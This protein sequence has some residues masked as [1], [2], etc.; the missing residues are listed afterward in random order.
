MTRSTAATRASSAHLG[1]VRA[2]LAAFVLLV[3][4][5]PLTLVNPQSASAY[6]P[7]TFPPAAESDPSVTVTMNHSP[8][9]PDPIQGQQF[10]YTVSFVFG[11]V[12]EAGVDR[13]ATISI[14][15]DPNAPFDSLPTVG[16]FTWAGGG[17]VDMTRGA[18]SATACTFTLNTLKNDTLNFQGSATVNAN[19]P[20][21]AA[22]LASADARITSTPTISLDNVSSVAHNQCSGTYRFVQRVGDAGAWLADMKFADVNGLGKVFLTPG[23]RTIRAYNDPSAS[24]DT[25]RFTAPGDVDITSE[26]MANATYVANDPSTPIYIGLD[27][28]SQARFSN[29]DWIDSLNWPYDPSTWTG[30]TWL[31]AGTEIVVERQVSYAGCFGGGYTGDP[32]RDRPF[33]IST[34]IARATT[35]AWGSDYDIFSMPGDTPPV[36]AVCENRLLVSHNQLNSGSTTA[37]WWQPGSSAPAHTKVLNDS[38]ST[39]KRVDAI[40]ATADH[41]TKLFGLRYNTAVNKP[42]SHRLITYDSASGVTTE[43]ATTGLADTYYTGMAFDH[44]GNLW[45]AS[46]GGTTRYLTKAQVDALVAGTSTTAAWTTGPTI[47]TTGGGRASGTADLAFDGL[48]NLYTHYGTGTVAKY[49]NFTGSLGSASVVPTPPTASGV[50]EGL[51]GLAFIGDTLY[52]SGADRNLYTVNWKG[53]LG[54]TDVTS[55]TNGFPLADSGSPSDFASCSFPKPDDVPPPS[56][57]AYKV[58]KTIINPD[59]SIQPVNGAE[60]SIP[61]QPRVINP[62]GSVTIDYLVTVTAVGTEAGQFPAITDTARVPAGFTLEGLALNGVS[63]PNPPSFTIPSA[64]LDPTGATDPISRTYRVTLTARAPDL[65]AVNWTEAGRCDTSGVGNPAHGG[66]FNRVTMA[67][68]QDGPNN[69][70][71]CAP[72]EAPAQLTLIKE[73]VNEAGQTVGTIPADSQ[74]F[75][76]SAFG[77]STISGSSPTSGATAASGRV[78]PGTY[79]LHEQGNHSTAGQYRQYAEW[80]CVTSA[81][82]PIA[83][84]GGQ[85]TVKTGDNITCR[86]KNTKIPKVH[87]VK[88]A[89]TPTEANPHIGQ[90][91]IPDAEGRFIASYTVTVTNTSGFATTTGEIT[92]RFRVPDG[93]VWDGDRTATVTRLGTAGTANDVP[94]TLTRD[95]LHQGAVLATSIADLP[96]GASYSFRIDIPLRLNLD[97][98]S[99]G[100]GTVY[101]Q[102]AQSLGVCESNTSPGGHPY[103]STA[104]G[105]PNVTSLAGEDLTYTDIPIEDNIACIPVQWVKF[106]VEK[107]AEG[108]EPGGIG[109]PVEVNEDGRTVTLTYHVTVRNTG[110]TAGTSPE[111][112]DT[113]TLPAGFE[114]QSV[115]VDDDPVTV[116]QDGTFTLPA[117]PLA[118]GL[119]T[120]TDASSRTFK[121]V[122]TAVAPLPATADWPAAGECEAVDGEPFTGGF[123]NKV[124][125]PGDTDGEENNEAC[126]ET[127]PPTF[128]VNKAA[129]AE[130]DEDGAVVDWAAP[131][132]TGATVRVGDDGAVTV[133]YRIEVTNNGNAPGTHPAINDT[134]TLPAGFELTSIRLGSAVGE[135]DLVFESQPGA[136]LVATHTFTIPAGTANMLKDATAYYYVTVTAVA[137]DLGTVDWENAGTCET[138]GAGNPA[139][140]GFFNL[141]TMDGD[142]DGPDNNDACVPVE[143]PVRPFTL[144]KQAEHCDASLPLCALDGASFVLFDTDP[145]V[146]GAEPLENGITVDTTNGP[147]FTSSELP[148]PATYW[149]VETRAPVGFQLLPAPVEFELTTTGIVL[150]DP[151]ANPTIT[152][153]GEEGAAFQ[154]DV[155]N[156]PGGELPQAGGEGTTAFAL[157]GLLLV[158]TGLFFSVRTP[159]KSPGRHALT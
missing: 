24:G 51:R 76:L 40:G 95:Q 33:G 158:G 115:T 119:P 147:R 63:Q 44:L 152:V 126:V 94:A 146:E 56:G 132:T 91:I 93:I 120:P 27:P 85:I 3:L 78:L 52:A 67:N 130:Y 157:A 13:S 97:A 7:A 100:T 134:V 92:D 116:A 136:G 73:I 10:T 89:T 124:T 68:D 109:D 82:Q 28:A 98:A 111:I 43:Y 39:N 30:N 141:V 19:L 32:D 104:S 46:N 25:I 83:V 122:V 70:D 71:A 110:E 64:R 8:T 133:H 61:G 143:P 129:P 144:L 118:A 12:I 75:T 108:G 139:A 18:C 131:G 148:V 138:E 87:I 103:T 37:Y 21:H 48:G 14:Y 42:G 84:D 121:I 36:P 114:V 35:D 105:I 65:N 127:T 26:V 153:S 29:A 96:D 80:S 74:Y 88:T 59:G 16:N 77:P 113:L 60:G 20:E 62:D 156:L 107:R 102:N 1:N 23:D 6:T 5:L 11:D 17:A 4:L 125:M 9:A 142:T 79:L 155:I 99:T 86:V 55:S 50:S 15:A 34:Q 47:Q 31:P 38:A 2:I 106:S 128:R 159:T 154:L 58:Q 57:P 150:T 22:V 66:F 81:N 54:L 41:P 117:V 72:V 149:L 151:E 145:T 69:N 123:R 135:G 140:G 90:T 49:A 45:V 137:P 112:T 101:D 53:N